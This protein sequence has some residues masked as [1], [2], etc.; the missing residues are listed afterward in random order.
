MFL[1]LLWAMEP[2]IVNWLD[3]RFATSWINVFDQNIRFGGIKVI[4]GGCGVDG[5]EAYQKQTVKPMRAHAHAYWFHPARYVQLN[6]WKTAISL[7]SSFQAYEKRSLVLWVQPSEELS[8]KLASL[9]HFHM[10]RPIITI[11][12]FVG[13]IAQS[14]LKT[15]LGK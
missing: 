14:H 11:K 1:V 12:D 15:T 10:E 13:L 3:C 4:F 2:A 7:K 8:V 6:K 9:R 5:W